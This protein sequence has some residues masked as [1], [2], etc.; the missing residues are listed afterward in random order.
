MAEPT[1]IGPDVRVEV[2]LPWNDREVDDPWSIWLA[3]EG[4]LVS[5]RGRYAEDEAKLIA[6]TLNGV[7]RGCAVVAAPVAGSPRF[8]Y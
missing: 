2:T 8:G 1:Y 6:R 3:E 7:L 4:A 5:L